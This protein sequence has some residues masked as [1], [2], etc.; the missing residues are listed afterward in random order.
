MILAP[1]R[2]AR[3]TGRSR[4]SCCQQTHSRG[5]G[6]SKK[7]NNTG[8][9]RTTV[10]QAYVYDAASVASH[11]VSQASGLS[12]GKGGS[13]RLTKGTVTDVKALKTS[14]PG[15]LS[16]MANSAQATHHP[17]KAYVIDDCAAAALPG[18]TGPLVPST[19]Q[20]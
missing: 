5:G 11:V 7:P 13:L 14:K 20:R 2:V 16:T 6:D 10:A 4:V 19:A 18:L 12:V 1:F 15:T 17:H 3:C 9:P 8:I